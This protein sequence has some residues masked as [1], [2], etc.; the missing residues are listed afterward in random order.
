[1]P[2]IIC[3]ARATKGVL[4]RIAAR[5]GQV[6]G[7]LHTDVVPLLEDND[8]RVGYIG[9]HELRGPADQIEA[10]TKRVLQ[11]ITG[12]TFDD[13][14]WQRIALTEQQVDADPRLLD[15][16][17]TKTDKRYKPSKCYEAV[18]CEVGKFDL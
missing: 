14:I 9:A 7:F 1:V 2:L 12:R 8:R 17:I 18:E 4:E 15:L 16:K 13:E 3:E 10:N 11:E 6:G 5:Y